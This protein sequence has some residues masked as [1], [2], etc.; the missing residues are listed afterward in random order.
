MSLLI[1]LISKLVIRYTT[2]ISFYFTYPGIFSFFCPL[3]KL[4]FY[5]SYKSRMFCEFIIQVLMDKE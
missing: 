1:I 3:N 4:L 5:I 2:F